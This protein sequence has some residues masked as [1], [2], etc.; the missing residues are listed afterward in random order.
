MGKTSFISRERAKKPLEQNNGRGQDVA[1]NKKCW[2]LTTNSGLKNQ[3]EAKLHL[4]DRPRWL[5]NEIPPKIWERVFLGLIGAWIRKYFAGFLVRTFSDRG[6]VVLM[7]KTKRQ[8]SFFP[9]FPV[10]V[11]MTCFAS[12]MARLGLILRY[13]LLPLD[14]CRGNR[15]QACR[16]APYQGTLF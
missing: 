12:Q 16:V 4:V 1:K 9:M 8:I 13:G 7:P 5:I 2:L 10:H 14:R 11:L 3:V 6:Q 15:T